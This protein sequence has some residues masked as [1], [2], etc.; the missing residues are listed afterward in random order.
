MPSPLAKPRPQITGFFAPRSPIEFLGF[1]FITCML[2]LVSAG[3]PI[4]Y[5]FI[6]LF[7]TGWWWWERQRTKKLAAATV[8]SVTKEPPRAARGLILL[9][10]PF[11]PR[12]QDLKDADRL[13]PLLDRVLQNPTPEIADF[14]ALNLLHSNLLPQ[15]QAVEYHLHQGK[16]RDLWL[17]TT[18]SYTLEQKTP[19]GIKSVAIKGSVTAAIILEKYLRLKYG[20]QQFDLHRGT[21]FQVRDY[22]YAGLWRL[23]EQIFRQA[24]YRDEALVADITGGTKMMSMAIAMACIPPGRRMQYMDSARDWQGNPLAQGEIKPVMIDV[25][26]ML[27]H[28][29]DTPSNSP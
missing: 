26:P 11:D 20:A 7:S 8:F 22:D 25:D 14:E 5:V 29:H 4:G 3:N 1:A 27:Y 12:S 24:G 18:A 19:D 6:P 23:T 13:T 9:L 10:S 21:N 28:P 16:L 17:I 15:I 2:A